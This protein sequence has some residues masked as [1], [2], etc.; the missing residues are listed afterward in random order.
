M[1]KED[2]MILLA[3]DGVQG[4]YY[5]KE[6]NSVIEAIGTVAVP[7]KNDNKY[8]GVI[9]WKQD[10]PLVKQVM[11]MKKICYKYDIL[12]DNN[13]LLIAREKKSWTFGEFFWGDAVDIL[14][15]SKKYNLNIEMIDKN[16]GETLQLQ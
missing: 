12:V 13:I 9:L 1:N 11:F 5:C 14:V 2:G 8:K 15:L 6:S 7:W 16:S 3:S 10:E 4:R